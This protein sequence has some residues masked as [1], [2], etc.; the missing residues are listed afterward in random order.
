MIA[1]TEKATPLDVMLKRSSGSKT[2][3]ASE[4]ATSVLRNVCTTIQRNLKEGAFINSKQR[5]QRP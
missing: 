5:E 2:F 4:E 1:F 3:T